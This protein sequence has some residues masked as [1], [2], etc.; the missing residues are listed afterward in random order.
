MTERRIQLTKGYEAIVDDED[1]AVLSQHRWQAKVVRQTPTS[2]PHV[3][4]VRSTGG[5]KKPKRMIY[6]HREIMGAKAR[7]IVDHI[8]RNPLDN[9]RDNLRFCTSSGNASNRVYQNKHGYRGVC[10]SR[11]KFSVFI[12]VGKKVIQR[13]GFSSPVEAARGYDA[14]ARELHGEFAVLNFPD[15]HTSPPP[16]SVA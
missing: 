6:M 13:G 8:N 14:L 15:T 2:D 16:P 12:S 3:C 5:G 9:R 7:Q 4:A 11:N 1:F 10:T